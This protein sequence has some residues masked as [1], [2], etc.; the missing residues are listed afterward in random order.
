MSLASWFNRN[1]GNGDYLPNGSRLT[2]DGSDIL[3]D[4]ENAERVLR[5]R[6]FAATGA[7]VHDLWR[8]RVAPTR[9]EWAAWRDDPTTRF[10]M[11]ALRNAVAAQ[12]QAWDDFSWQGGC[13]DQLALSEYRTR[14]DAYES[15]EAGVYEDFCAWAG[16]EPDPLP[17]ED[18]ERA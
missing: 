4:M 3:H 2:T 11:A 17:V 1:F 15:I 18:E 13:A 10:V 12:K 8:A 9:D 7:T 5:A 6:D 16:V 14:A